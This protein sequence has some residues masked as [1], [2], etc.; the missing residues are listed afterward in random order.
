MTVNGN[1]TNCFVIISQEDHPAF[2]WDAETVEEVKTFYSRYPSFDGTYYFSSRSA[3]YFLRKRE[4]EDENA[5]LLV[6]GVYCAEL[7]K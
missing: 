3:N 1:K 2:A 5:N 7:D 6:V 4:E